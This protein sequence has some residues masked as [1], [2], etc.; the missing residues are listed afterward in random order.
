MKR[1]LVTGAK[2]FIGRNVCARLMHLEDLEVC[3]F[4]IENGEAEL[5]AWLNH[6]DVIFHLAGVNRP[7]NIGEYEKGN[8]EFTYRICDVLR[9]LKRMP[10]IVMS[11]SIQAELDNPY[12]VSKRRAEES[13]QAFSKETGAPVSIYRLK[14]VF[15]KWCL[16]DYNSV[17]ATFCHNIANDLPI[18]ISDPGREIELVYIDDIVERFLEELRDPSGS[19]TGLIPDTIPST[20]IRLG[21]LVGRIQTFHEMKT[22]LMTPDFSERFNQCLYATYLSYVKPEKLE[23][24]LE[25]KA[26][27]RGN[28]AEFMKSCHFGQIF[29]SRTRPGITRGNHYHHTKTEKFL[30]VDGEGLIRMRHIESNDVKEHRVCGTDYRVI[31]IPP[32]YTHSISNIGEEEMITLFWASEVFD[33]DHPDTYYFE[34]DSSGYTL[35]HCAKNP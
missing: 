26:D 32:G 9:Q 8:A 5:K 2:G 21:E 35:N 34:V 4:D 31:D 23:Y 13:L 1:V 28:L 6:A 12:G 10:R 22:N 19:D 7:Q 16:P 14:N 17:T 27:S 30:V 18:S 3:R 24:G 25:I 11:S 15:G 33:P 29:V 20:R